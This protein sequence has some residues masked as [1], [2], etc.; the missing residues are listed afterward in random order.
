MLLAT[1]KKSTKVFSLKILVKTAVKRNLS[2][3]SDATY[4]M[5]II[6]RNF[7]GTVYR[8]TVKEEERLVEEEQP[9]LEQPRVTGIAAEET[10][11]G[12]SS[13]LEAPIVKVISVEVKVG[14]ERGVLLQRWHQEG[15][16]SQVVQEQDGDDIGFL[17]AL[18]QGGPGWRG[19]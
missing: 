1:V 7:N 10:G 16:E 11:P 14:L 3:K 13:G 9:T 4:T 18:H 12:A 19:D 8:V 6:E 17:G 5:T 15:G 2:E